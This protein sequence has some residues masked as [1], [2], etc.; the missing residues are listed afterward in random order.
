MFQEK[1][2]ESDGESRAGNLGSLGNVRRKSPLQ[3]QAELGVL[4]LEVSVS[5]VLL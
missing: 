3:K 5:C 1:S 2:R 4:L